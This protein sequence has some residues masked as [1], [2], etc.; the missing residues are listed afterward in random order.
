MEHPVDA[1]DLPI[2]AVKFRT[3]N[4]A[5]TLS[6]LEQTRPRQVSAVKASTD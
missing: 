4:R 5:D 3:S 2:L 6:E 1:F